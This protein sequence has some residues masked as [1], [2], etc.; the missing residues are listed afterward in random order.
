MRPMTA[1]STCSWY[2]ADPNTASTD[3][4]EMASPSGPPRLRSIRV[5]WRLPRS[6]RMSSRHPTPLVSPAG[7][8]WIQIGN[9]GGFLPAPVVVPTQPITWII[10]PTRFNV[11]NVDK[12][13]LLLASAER[14]DVIVDFSQYAG[15]TLI[16]YN[17]APA[18]F[19]ARVVHLRLLHRRT[20]SVLRWRTNHPARATG[21]TPAPSCRSRSRPPPRRPPST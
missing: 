6:T 18:A 16:L 2:V 5:S 4:N 15:K 1:S 9:E 12:H 13:S 10:D 8:S 7:P 21:P 3:L 20:G 11:G 14:A 19:P 17:D